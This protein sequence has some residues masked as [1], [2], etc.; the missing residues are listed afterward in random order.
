MII[1]ESNRDQDIAVNVCKGKKLTNTRAAGKDDA[2]Q[3]KGARDMSLEQCIAFLND[4]EYLE[5]TP[6]ELRLR[7]RFLKADDRAKY[8]K[9][10]NSAA[11]RR[12]EREPRRALI[13]IDGHAA[14][15]AL[16]IQN[17]LQKISKGQKL[18]QRFFLKIFGRAL[19]VFR[20]LFDRKFYSKK[21]A[22]TREK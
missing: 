11:S 8:N 14:N 10:K 19:R 13:K 16:E 22:E 15:F 1:G 18:V 4:D 12:A 21:I 17:R 9:N 3:L 20:R 5:V 7:K 2:V 6:K